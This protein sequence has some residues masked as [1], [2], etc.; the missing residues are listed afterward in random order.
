VSV[1]CSPHKAGN[2][3]WLGVRKEGTMRIIGTII[4]LCIILIAAAFTL[5]NAQYVEVNY[6]IGSR[7]LPLA[8]LL[9]ISL[10]FGVVISLLT[11][12]FSFITLKAKNKWLEMK[13]NSARA[14][15]NKS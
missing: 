14:H 6:L 12:G 10:I 15:T 7:E 4:I 2:I 5:L 11:L 1:C 8:V 3:T 13:L 9:L